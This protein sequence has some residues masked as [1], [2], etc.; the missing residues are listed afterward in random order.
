MDSVRKRSELMFE[1]DMFSREFRHKG[2]YT[3]RNDGICKYNITFKDSEHLWSPVM[4]VYDVTVHGVNNKKNT[5]CIKLS[6]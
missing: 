4:Y 6:K 3:N 2:I 5:R 1:Y